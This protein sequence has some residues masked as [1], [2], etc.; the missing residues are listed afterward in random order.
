MGM[1]AIF[2]RYELSPIRIQYTITLQSISK[3]L[4]NICTV[5][6]GIFAVSSILDSLTR[7]GFGILGFGSMEDLPSHGST[8]SAAKR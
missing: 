2:F 6:G 8:L 5:C 4:V 1:P 3:Y 7:N